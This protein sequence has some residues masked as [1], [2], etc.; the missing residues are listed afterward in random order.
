MV[1]LNTV[2]L[3]VLL[4]DARMTDAELARRVGVTRQCIYE[5]TKGYILPSFEMSIRIYQVLQ[6]EIEKLEEQLIKE[7]SEMKDE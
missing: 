4:A 3:N 2:S 1:G 5:Y 6:S 7:E